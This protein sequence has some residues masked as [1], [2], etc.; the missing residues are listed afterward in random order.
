MKPINRG[1]RELFERALLGA[2]GLAL[3][4]Q[5]LP[6]AQGDRSADAAVLRSDEPAHAQGPPTQNERRPH[7]ELFEFAWQDSARKRAVPARFYRPL[8]R[9]RADGAARPLVLFSHGLGGS[10]SGY[11]YLSDY[12]AT[13]G[14]ACLHPQH[15]GSDRSIWSA[16]SPFTV[17]SRLLAASQDAEAIARVQDLRFCLDQLFAS[18][19]ADQIDRQRI[20]VAGHSYGANSALLMGG[21]RV[22]RNGIGVDL[23]DARPKAV[24]AM[25]APPFYGEAS[26]TS[27]LSSMKLPSLHITC[28]EDVIRIPG[29]LSGADD[30]V[31]IFEATAGLPKCLTMFEGGSHSVFT[32]REASGGFETNRRIK[33]ASCL[34]IAAFLRLTF[35]QDPAGMRRWQSQHDDMLRQFIWS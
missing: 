7:Y 26:W 27:I 20:V 19:F 10:R 6:A 15:I 8:A 18:E 4:P 29:L 13:E 31:A 28:S 17:G 22:V 11:R 5:D 23:R 9:D 16:G 24:I 34:L 25:S 35:D 14:I 32:D 21:A 3:L 1:R 30:R 12:L 2:A 33:R